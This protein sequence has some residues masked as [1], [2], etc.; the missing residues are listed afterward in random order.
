[1]TQAQLSAG[2]AV[3][4]SVSIWRSRLRDWVLRHRSA[5]SFAARPH[6]LADMDRRLLND[7]GLAWCDVAYGEA[8]YGVQAGVPTRP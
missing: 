5:P 2:H 1:M 4:H 6:A 7:I 8:E 3:E